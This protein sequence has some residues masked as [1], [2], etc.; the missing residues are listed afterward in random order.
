MWSIKGKQHEHHSDQTH[1]KK[2]RQRRWTGQA[3][4]FCE[5]RFNNIS[6]RCRYE[7]D[8]DV[9]P[10]GGSSEHTVIRVKQYRY[11]KKSR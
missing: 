7:K 9:Y 1:E 5:Y 10:V 8:R 4:F 2:R 11:E 6:Y 3:V